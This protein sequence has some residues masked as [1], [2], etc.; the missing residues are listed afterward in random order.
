ML[1]EGIII[2][3]GILYGRRLYLTTDRATEVAEFGGDFIIFLKMGIVLM[4][5]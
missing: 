4:F 2:I 1:T 3:P 5:Q